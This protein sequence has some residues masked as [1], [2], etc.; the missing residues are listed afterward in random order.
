MA[1]N[2]QPFSA[3]A[4]LPSLSLASP[5]GDVTYN[6]SVSR[7]SSVSIH[8]AAASSA[9]AQLPRIHEKAWFFHTALLP[10]LQTSTV[11]RDGSEPQ[12]CSG[13]AHEEADP[14]LVRKNVGP[15]GSPKSEGQAS[16]CSLIGPAPTFCMEPNHL[17]FKDDLSLSGPGAS[18]ADRYSLSTLYTSRCLSLGMRR[19]CE[20]L[21]LQLPSEADRDTARQLRT[22]VARDT[23][24]PA[25]A[26]QALT[27]LLPYCTELEYIDFCNAGLRS[28]CGFMT[29]VNALLDALICSVGDKGI[30]TALHTLDLSFNEL[31]DRTGRRLVRLIQRRPRLRVVN[32]DGTEISGK[33]KAR[34]AE[35][36]HRNSTACTSSM[37][38]SEANAEPTIAATATQLLDVVDPLEKRNAASVLPSD[39]ADGLEGKPTVVRDSDGILWRATARARERHSARSSDSRGSVER[40]ATGDQ[41]TSARN[42]GAAATDGSKGSEAEQLQRPVPSNGA[43]ALDSTDPSPLVV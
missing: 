31:N 16:S 19:P 15:V 17:F 25:K 22:I 18:L 8:V 42:S 10:L 11:R 3:Q 6:E 4:V 40:K 5:K 13:Q 14:L 35:E 32:T 1:E 12:H 38:G 33:V 39:L 36:L 27:V 2:R 24:V 20:H 21:L 23:Y 43:A 29:G 34:I 28:R 30:G 7:P 41:S 9:A 26:C 37:L